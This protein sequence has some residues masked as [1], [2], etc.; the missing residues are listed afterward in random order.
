MPGVL[1]V[2]VGAP[3]LERIQLHARTAALSHDGE[4]VGQSVEPAANVIGSVV[5]VLVARMMTGERGD[6]LVEQELFEFIGV[7]LAQLAGFGVRAAID[8]RSEV[9]V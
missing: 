8:R 5:S 7:H 6:E 3:E 2:L 1:C 4:V 9:E